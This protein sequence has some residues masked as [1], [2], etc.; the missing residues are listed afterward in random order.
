MIDIKAYTYDCPV[1][2]LS[3]Q[4][5]LYEDAAN[6]LSADIDVIRPLDVSLDSV[7]CKEADQRD[8]CD[9]G[10]DELVC[11]LDRGILENYAESKVLIRL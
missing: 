7:F 10:Y 2:A 5:V 9:F 1:Y 4:R 3:L 6:L 8:S 11:G